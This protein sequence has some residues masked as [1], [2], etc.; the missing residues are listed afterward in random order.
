M[1]YWTIQ[2]K[3]IVETIVKRGIYQSDFSK[4]RYLNF[5]LYMADLY[6]LILDSYNNINNLHLNG[7]IYAFARSDGRSINPIK[8]IT[9]FYRFMNNKKPIINSLWKTLTTDDSIILE[10]N[11]EENFNPLFVDI[12]DIQF[13]IPPILCLPPY[14]EQSLNRICTD[15]ARGQ[16]SESE[17]P[18]YVI[19]AHLP[20]IK[21]ENIISLYPS[22]DLI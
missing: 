13:L 2:T 6:S 17:F 12:N 1:K 18:S 3:D 4:S 5:N 16:I 9:E 7:V 14:T 11:Y 10:L 20:Y 8:D 22:F 21:A 19:Q 15:I